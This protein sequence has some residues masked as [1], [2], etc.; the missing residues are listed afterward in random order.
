MPARL[1]YWEADEQMAAGRYPAA[2][3]GYRQIAEKYPKWADEALFRTGYLYA[4]PKNPERDYQKA[5]DAF[6]K[7]VAEHPRSEYRQ[8]AESFLHVLGELT[9]RERRASGL[10]RQADTLEK[11]VEML[12]KQIEQMKAIDRNLEEKRRQA[13][14]K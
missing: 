1:Q 14:R 8:P 4:H 7:L 11:Q 6:K 9:H 2:L 13:P 12:E 10:K 3:Q 5:L